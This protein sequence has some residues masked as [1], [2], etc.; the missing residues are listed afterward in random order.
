MAALEKKSPWLPV[1]LYPQPY[2]PKSTF[3]PLGHDVTIVFDSTLFV[4]ISLSIGAWAAY[5][6]AMS[7][8]I[9]VNFD[10]FFIRHSSSV[11]YRLCRFCWR[12]CTVAAAAAVSTYPIRTCCRPS[13]ADCREES[14]PYY[15]Y[16]NDCSP[17]VSTGDTV[18]AMGWRSVWKPSLVFARISGSGAYATETDTNIYRDMSN[19][20]DKLDKN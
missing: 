7:I 8:D 11:T 4:W 14:W 1:K 19:P 13:S 10:F 6:R 2:A 12:S 17:R 20:S 5:T 3:R 9:F 15:R 18:S 16:S